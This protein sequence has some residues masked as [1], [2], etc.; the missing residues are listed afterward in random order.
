MAGKIYIGSISNPLFLFENEN[1]E[2]CEVVLSSSLSG[3][4]LAID[5]L[6]PTVYS[7]AYIRVRFI[8]KN[9]AGLITADGKEFCCYPGDGFL[10][11][12]PYATPI[13][14]YFGDV[15]MGKFYSKQITRSGKTWFDILAVSAAGILD[16]QRHYGGIYTGQ[17]FQT[18]ASEIIGSGFPF[19]CASDAAAVKIYGWLPIATRREN[20]HQLLFACGISMSKD[21]NGDMYFCYPD[22]DTVK[23]VPDNRMFLGGNVDYLTP[24]TRAEVTEHSFLSLE[25]DKIVTLFDNTQGSDAA[26]H[27]FVSFQD[28]PVHNLSVTGTMTLVESGVNYAIVNGIG[29]LTGKKYT[30]TTRVLQKSTN[31]NGDEKEVSVTDATLVNVAN[32]ENVLSRVLSYY[33]S[34]KTTSCDLIVAGEKPGDQL[35]FTNPYDE[36]ERAFLSSMDIRASSFLR[37]SCELVT[38]Y[39]PTGNGNNFTRVSVLTGSGSWTVPVGV[40][41]IRVSVIQ[42]GHGG[43]GGQRG[44]AGKYNSVRYKSTS[45]NP[46]EL[47]VPNSTEVGVGGAPGTPGTGGKV[48]STTIEVVPGQVFQYSSGIGGVGGNGQTADIE[49]QDG[50]EGTHSTFGS[51]SSENGSTVDGGYLDIINN[52]LYATTGALG[53]SGSPGNIGGQTETADGGGVLGG[54]PA[55][56]R[57]NETWNRRN[58]AAPWVSGGG[59]QGGNAYGAAGQ[60]GETMVDTFDEDCENNRDSTHAY[61]GA[62][63]G[64]GATPIKPST[65]NALGTGGGAGHG[66]GGGATGAAFRFTGPAVTISTTALSLGGNG[67]DGGEGGDGAPGGIIIYM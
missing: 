5:Q 14:Y 39:L 18:V 64:D 47:F 42:G 35:S 43:H 57:W 49:A 34:A 46:Y 45:G 3:D 33:A 4:E 17:T 53:T 23:N 12:L 59:G 28:A 31:S 61:R 36:A 37:A 20:L 30:H 58:H 40:T 1:V 7:A 65:P 66:G 52:I 21:S 44:T 9:S 51:Y 38:G 19:S 11:K 50:T 2:K 24:A 54:K 8:P 55:S 62:D 48:F 32:S 22:S 26:N 63:G 15:L 13:W 67:G 56:G 10:D 6:M 27:T 41:R 60:A 25:S 16:G 29:T